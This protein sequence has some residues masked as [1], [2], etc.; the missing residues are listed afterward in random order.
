MKKKSAAFLALLLALCLALSSCAAAGLEAPALFT[1][2]KRSAGNF[3]AGARDLISGNTRIIDKGIAQYRL[4]CPAFLSDSVREEAD[5]L[6]GAVLEKTGTALP[7]STLPE[8]NDKCIFLD[9]LTPDAARSVQIND[10]VFRIYFDGDHIRI[11][12]TNEVM[13]AEAVRY[14]NTA[15]L[16]TENATVGDGY[17]SVPSDTDI[18]S[19]TAAVFDADVKAQFVIVRPEKASDRVVAAAQQVSDA[20]RNATG[21]GVKIKSDFRVGTQASEQTEILVGLC[22][23]EGVSEQAA[24]LNSTS[25]YIGSDGTDIRL[26]GVTDSMTEK[27]VEA[28]LDAFVRGS[29]PTAQK[30]QLL[31][32]RSFS[33]TSRNDSLIL[34]NGGCSEYMLVYAANTGTVAID[35]INRFASDFYYYTGA[36]LPVFSDA[37]RPGVSEKEIRIGNT[38]RREGSSSVEYNAWRISVN[39]NT[40]EVNGGCDIALS[41][42]LGELSG[43]LLDLVYGQN[44]FETDDNGVLQFD[45]YGAKLLALSKKLTLTGVSAPGLE[46]LTGKVDIGEG[47][48]MM[49]RTCAEI[50]DFESYLDLIS[51]LGY[52][53]YVAR[54]VGSGNVRTATYRNDNHILNISFADSEKTLRVTVDP[55]DQT[56]LPPLY[57]SAAAVCD[58]LFIQFGNI[59]KTV[60]CGMSYAVR[61]TDGTFLIV[62]GGWTDESISDSLYRNLRNYNVLKGDPVISCWIFTHGHVDHIGTFITFSQKYGENVDLKGICYSFPTEEQTLVNGGWSVNY[63][64]NRIRR[65]ASRFGGDV[66][67]YKARTGQI[68]RFAG[69]EMEMLFTF[70][71]Y[72]QPRKLSFFNDSS[73]VFRL[74]L[75]DRSGNI[76]SFMML[77]DASV[78]TSNILVSR[79]GSYLKSDAVQVAHHGYTGGTDAVY[80]AIE[81]AVVFWPCPLVA[82][83]G[84][85]RFASPT[86]SPV[87]RNMLDKEYSKVLYVGGLGDTVLTIEQ[88]KNREIIGIGMEAVKDAVPPKDPESEETS[89][90]NAA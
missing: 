10:A 6:R 38:N 49:Y 19:E 78:S 52:T 84:S 44:E 69:C 26:F 63:H 37:A 54:K 39:G 80:N 36:T 16:Q 17:L 33:Y 31:L 18:T 70:E 76:Q 28:F 72:P 88:V 40:V 23:R 22:D 67:I 45:P 55:A 68:Y 90:G 12:A 66:A 35:A 42:A 59:Y 48:W 89:G 47:G 2:L 7:V 85:L 75:T 64:Q 50:S 5:A 73:L 71:D 87:T 58:P 25:Y 4:V 29:V 27:A 65:Y 61:L 77:G 9:L 30:G 81:A 24:E 15:Y 46:N 11:A 83:N 62:D 41:D 8:G 79:Y 57:S 43:T 20:I 21:A 32:P 53:E 51:A 34:A 82:P 1:S 14:F 74:T 56:D 13:L 60:D 3:F 86:W